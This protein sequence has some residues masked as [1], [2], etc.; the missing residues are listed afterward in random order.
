MGLVSAVFRR[1]TGKKIHIRAHHTI[2]AVDVYNLCENGLFC[3]VLLD[4]K[5]LKS[6]EMRVITKSEKRQSDV[7]F[8]GRWY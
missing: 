2:F 5:A 1:G 7:L 3:Q 8:K 4:R 6:D